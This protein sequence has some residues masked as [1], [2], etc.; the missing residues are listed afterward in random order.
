M[1]HFCLYCKEVFTSSLDASLSK[2]SQTQD[3]KHY[4]LSDSDRSHCSDYK[5]FQIIDDTLYFDERNFISS[6]KQFGLTCVPGGSLGLLISD[7]SHVLCTKVFR[8]YVH[9]HKPIL[10]TNDF[11]WRNISMDQCYAFPH[12]SI[13]RREMIVLQMDIFP[14]R[15]LLH[16]FKLYLGKTLLNQRTHSQRLLDILV[17][18]TQ[19]SCDITQSFFGSSGPTPYIHDHPNT[20]K[21]LWKKGEL[22]NDRIMDLKPMPMFIENALPAEL[23]SVQAWG[24]KIFFLQDFLTYSTGCCRHRAL[25]NCLIL[26]ILSYKPLYTQ[27]ID[28]LDESLLEP[29]CGRVSIKICATRI[30]K[31]VRVAETSGAHAV[32]IVSAFDGPCQGLYVIDSNR[33]RNK[34]SVLEIFASASHRK[35]AYDWYGEHVTNVWLQGFNAPLNKFERPGTLQENQLLIKKHQHDVLQPHHKFSQI[36]EMQESMFQSELLTKSMIKRQ[37]QELI[38][39]DKHQAYLVSEQLLRNEERQRLAIRSDQY[40][41]HLATTLLL[42]RMH[43]ILKKYQSTYFDF[44]TTHKYLANRDKL[45]KIAK[46]G[47]LGLID[48]IS[49]EYAARLEDKEKLTVQGKKNDDLERW[50][51]TLD[52][53]KALWKADQALWEQNNP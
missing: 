41:H 22:G 49:L 29:F 46:G 7:A 13:S 38:N 24:G 2:C 42:S 48:G 35:L 53:A 50:L 44:W 10:I 15:D 28:V 4:I 5:A 23:R 52:E 39:E 6:V 11:E 36:L 45:L 33:V 3:G 51:F 30:Y 1:A 25:L 34:N 32:T 40:A 8:D 47:A 14:H 21:P 43:T 31:N 18:L 27:F 17:K 9:K 12:P 16:E 20:L 26:T 19:Y 37:G